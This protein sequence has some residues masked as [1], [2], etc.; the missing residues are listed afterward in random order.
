M[1][2]GID[3]NLNGDTAGD[4]VLLNPQGVSGT[5]SGVSALTNSGGQTVAYL[6]TNPS[7]QYI[8]AGLG[9]LEPNNGDSVR[10]TTGSDGYTVSR[11]VLEPQ[12]PTFNQDH[13]FFPS[14]ARTL[15]LGF[16]FQ[17]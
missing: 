16:K 9:A 17:F 10:P 8:Q 12:D 7:A 5:G 1:Q 4:R 2:S 14:H 3:S 6:A 15:Q 11:G 13:N